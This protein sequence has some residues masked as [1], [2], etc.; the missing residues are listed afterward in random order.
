MKRLN[1]DIY[2]NSTTKQFGERGFECML[3]VVLGIGTLFLLFLFPVM[4]IAL[5]IFASCFL[6]IGIKKYL[7]NIAQGKYAQIESIYS[8]W[9][10]CIKAFCLKVAMVLISFLWAIVFIIPGIVS[11]LNYSMASFI[12]AEDEDV[13]S[14][15]AMIKSKK[16]VYG[17][18]AQ[19]FIVYLSYFFV[20][21]VALCIF[22]AIGCAMKQFLA[23]NYW[24]PIVSMG[25][26]FMFVLI[27]FIIPYFELGL[28]NVYLTIKESYIVET[29]P[30]TTNKRIKRVSNTSNQIS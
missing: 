7:I 1:Y 17:Y 29:K 3:A 4:G 26:A 13:S 11:A 9:R 8:K 30:K 6:C 14:L 10:I 24:V 16:L 28:T 23:V 22:G 12:M 18:R 21:L 25:L 19:I 15:D 27:I 2:F 20:T 5:G